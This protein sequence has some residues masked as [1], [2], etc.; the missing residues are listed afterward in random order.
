MYKLNPFG[1]FRFA[2]VS[3]WYM[4]GSKAFMDEVRSQLV[5][6]L[7]YDIRS[8]STANKLWSD[9]LGLQRGEIVS[10]GWVSVGQRH[11]IENKYDDD[12]DDIG[13]GSKL[14]CFKGPY[15]FEGTSAETLN[16]LCC[17]R[18]SIPT[19]KPAKEAWFSWAYIPWLTPLGLA[20]LRRFLSVRAQAPKW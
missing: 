2:C 7:H 16:F 3:N 13:R 4:I 1:H 8:S 19:M 9:N 20:C 10:L 12:I 15:V 11:I 14:Y 18:V 17:E 5:Q 6:I